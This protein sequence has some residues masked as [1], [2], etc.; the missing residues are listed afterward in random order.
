MGKESTGQADVMTRRTSRRSPARR[1]ARTRSGSASLVLSLLAALAAGL[2]FALTQ[3]EET[4][5]GQPGGSVS[6]EPSAPA[7]G[8]PAGGTGDETAQHRGQEQQ[9]AGS[10]SVID[11]DTIEIGGQ[12]VRLTGV[13]APESG[14]RCA[15]A[16]GRLYRCGTLAANAL[17]AWINRNPVTCT[18]TGKDRYERLLG[19]CSV[20]GESLGQW[21]V[22]NGHAL[23]YRAYSTDFVAAED[24]ARRQMR[25]VWAGEFTPPWEWRRGARLPGETPARGSRE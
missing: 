10:A 22:L 4:A 14:Q 18:I 3:P 5:D 23:A 15:D 17:D 25:G 11:A 12:R 2:W 6:G 7:A 1:Q 8:A 16:S 21:L 20:R 9:I 24:T 13:D 19:A